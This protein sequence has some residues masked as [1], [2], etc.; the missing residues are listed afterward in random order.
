VVWKSPPGAYYLFDERNAS[1]IEQDVR[2]ALA[3]ALQTG[4]TPTEIAAAKSGLLE[5]RKVARSSDGQLAADLAEHLYLGRDFTW[6]ASFEQRIAA[7][8][9]SDI[10]AHPAKVPRLEWMDAA[11]H[12]LLPCV[13][14]HHDRHAR[15]RSP[16]RLH[17]Q[18]LL[19]ALRPRC[20]S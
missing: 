14:G 1:E 5:T 8:T 19:P 18:W 15:S 9:P 4:F 6:N 11:Q 20:V 12:A 16:I 2:G 13:G 3:R 10:L 17:P 7:A